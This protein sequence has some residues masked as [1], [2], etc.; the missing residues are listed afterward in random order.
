MVRTLLVCE[1]NALLATSL[2]ALLTAEENI[3]KLD[4]ADDYEHAVR[5]IDEK[6]YSLVICFAF[7]PLQSLAAK[8]GKFRERTC[9]VLLIIDARDRFAI[10]NLS[11]FQADGL[12]STGSPYNEFKIAIHTITSRCQR[13]IS[14]HLLS[15]SADVFRQTSPFSNLSSKELDVALAILQGKR[16]NDIADELHISHKTVS[17]YKT[18]IFKKLEINNDVQLFIYA[19]KISSSSQL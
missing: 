1:D 10:S 17:T 2:A 7:Y 13:Y 4:L 6:S 3:G 9:S 5:L 12:I 16:N 8:L 11:R 15:G 18:R 14:P 19:S